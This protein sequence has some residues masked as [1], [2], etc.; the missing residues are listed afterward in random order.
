VQ[1]RDDRG[2]GPA[3]AFARPRDGGAG[4]APRSSAREQL[5]RLEHLAR[6]ELAALQQ[7]PT[8]L[9]AAQL[10]CAE[11]VGMAWDLGLDAGQVASG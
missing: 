6:R 1:I 3:G 7:Q 2:P 4:N 10:P 5:Q 11:A 9:P 8:A